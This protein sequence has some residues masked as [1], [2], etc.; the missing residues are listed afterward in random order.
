MC[1][2]AKYVEVRKFTNHTLTTC[3]KG[4]GNLIYIVDLSNPDTVGTEESVGSLLLV[5][6]PDFGGCNVHRQG[7]WDSQMYPVY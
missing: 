7:V 3:C 5:R 1:S 4:F 2:Y 6:C